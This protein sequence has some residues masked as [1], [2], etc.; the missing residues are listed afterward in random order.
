MADQGYSGIR[1]VPTS[2]SEDGR[3]Q[4]DD[5]V[6]TNFQSYQNRFVKN[7]QFGGKASCMHDMALT[8]MR[9]N[10]NGRSTKIH[11][12]RAPTPRLLAVLCRNRDVIS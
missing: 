3:R 1:R 7:K 2:R 4:D 6:H 10:Q 12:S 9:A 8:E 5:D 11:D